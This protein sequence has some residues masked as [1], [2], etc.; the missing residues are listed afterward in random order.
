MGN[1]RSYRESDS[2]KLLSIANEAFS[3]EIER[4]MSPFSQDTFSKWAQ[5]RGCVI[6]VTEKDGDVVGFMILTE[7]NIEA[8]AQI[9]LMGVEKS[10]RGRGIGKELVKSAITHVSSKKQV[11]LKLFTRP[12]NIG[13]SKVC[14]ELGFVPEAHLKKDYLGEDLVLYSYFTL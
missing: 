5:R 9:Q 14:I 12:W 10:Q 6:T 8:P 13:M 1:I 3:D 4:G 11:K 7:G 2:D